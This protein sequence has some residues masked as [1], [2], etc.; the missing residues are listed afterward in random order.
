M[1]KKNPKDLF[2]NSHRCGARAG[3]GDISESLLECDLFPDHSSHCS[4]FVLLFVFWEEFRIYFPINVLLYD[5]N[6]DKVM[7]VSQLPHTARPN[8]STVY[9]MEGSVSF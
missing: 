5:N 9:V 6:Q 2:C 8:M 1:I 4:G 7:Q 3:A